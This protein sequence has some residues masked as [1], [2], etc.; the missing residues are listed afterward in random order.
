MKTPDVSQLHETA[1]IILQEAHEL[2]FEKG[3]EKTSMREIAERV[4][5]SKAAMYHHFENKE[6]ILYTLC[7][8]AGEIINES[9]SQAIARNEGS[10]AGAREQL[11]DILYDYTTSYLKNKNFNKILLHEIESLPPEKKRV[12]LDYEKSNLLQLKGYLQRMIKQG[13]LRP[14]NLTVLTFSLFAAVHWLY[15]WYRP[16]RSLSIKEIVEN[17]VD[18][19]L[20]GAGVKDGA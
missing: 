3:Y 17:I 14:V 13:K 4:G 11:T 8:Q 20:N 7:V 9:M 6:R 15:F 1:Q 10:G 16:D 18:V 5:I 2:F 19:Y 12:I